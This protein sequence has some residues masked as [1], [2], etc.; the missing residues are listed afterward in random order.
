MH[1]YDQRSKRKC[2]WDFGKDFFILMDNAV[3]QKAMV[4]VRNYRDIK[5]IK[6]D[7]SRNY[8]ISEPNNQTQKKKQLR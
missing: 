3:F 7:K 5:L 4:N 6:T 8:V 2:K 1:W